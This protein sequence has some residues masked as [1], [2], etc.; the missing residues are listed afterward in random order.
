MCLFVFAVGQQ[1]IFHNAAWKMCQ[2]NLDLVFAALHCTDIFI[3]C[4]DFYAVVFLYLYT[5]LRFFCSFH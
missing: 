4:L 2:G 1:E 5:F 3:I